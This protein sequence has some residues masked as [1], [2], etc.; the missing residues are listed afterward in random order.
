MLRNSPKSVSILLFSFNNQLLKSNMSQKQFTKMFSNRSLTKIDFKR[1]II[2]TITK[3]SFNTT[4]T[5][6]VNEK[7]RFLRSENVQTIET[8][9]IT[10]VNKYERIRIKSPFNLN[11]HP[12]SPREYPLMNKVFLTLYGD[13]SLGFNK[14]EWRKMFDIQYDEDQGTL[15]IINTLTEIGE[16]K[17][18]EECAQT[19][20]CH[21][22]VP[23][24]AGMVFLIFCIFILFVL[25]K[26]KRYKC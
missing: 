17:L 6:T 12:L 22:S 4:Q 20:E 7:N 15:N 5:E 24:Q 13:S 9:T 14:A 21:L 18:I 3:R 16:E 11:I 1:P 23:Y 10:N 8:I 26:K 19:L 2:A 25:I